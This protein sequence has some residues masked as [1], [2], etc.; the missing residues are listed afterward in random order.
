MKK[1][2][3]NYLKF[4]ENKGIKK[5]EDIYDELNDSYNWEI[6]DNLIL[7]KNTKLELIIKIYINIC[8]D[9]KDFK[10]NELFKANEYIRNIIE[11]YSSNLSNNQIE[12]LHLNMIELYMAID[13]IVENNNNE[14]S[15]NMYE[16]MGNLLFIL[17]KNKLYFMKDLNNFIERDKETQINI[18]KVVKYT[19]S[20]SGNCSKQYH[21]DFKFTKL[22]HNNNIFTTYVTDQLN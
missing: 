4:L 21:N 20:A 3:E 13:Y 1:D 8:K 5:K 2:F 11:Y 6:I 17:L 22:F 19:I 7:K 16:I 10:N 18:A 12:I 15:I 14:N 9:K